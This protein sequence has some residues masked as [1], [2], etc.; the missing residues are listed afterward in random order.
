MKILYAVQGT[1]NG[2]ITRSAAIIPELMKHAK[3]DVLISGFAYNLKLPFD[4]KYK[5]E[6][7]SF[8]F[9]KRGGIDYFQTLIN[10]SYNSN[11][12]HSIASVYG[13]AWMRNN[14]QLRSSDTQKEI[15]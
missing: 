13:E 2:H 1:G 14:K 10:R 6:G 12:R 8:C 15:P 7:M 9:G 11:H 4:V 3:V 5:M